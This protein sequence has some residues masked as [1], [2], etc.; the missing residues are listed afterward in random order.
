VRHS[1][2]SGH[3]DDV[4]SGDGREIGVGSF[5]AVC[6]D[7]GSVVSVFW[8]APTDARSTTIKAAITAM[9]AMAVTIIRIRRGALCLITI[10]N[11]NNLPQL[12]VPRY[13]LWSFVW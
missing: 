11:E 3:S 5:G 7:R 1:R 6:S 9:K 10:F 4:V 2:R 12:H 13:L 8:V